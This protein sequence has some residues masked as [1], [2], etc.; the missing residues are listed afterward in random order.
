M[1]TYYCTIYYFIQKQLDETYNDGNFVYCDISL[2][3]FKPL[4][5]AIAR[6]PFQSRK[7]AMHTCSKGTRL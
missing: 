1:L 7:L 5:M 6:T 2:F 3:F 4:S